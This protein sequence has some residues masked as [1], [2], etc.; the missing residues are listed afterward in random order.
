MWVE[1]QEKWNSGC[2]KHCPKGG[3]AEVSA[4][5]PLP[6]PGGFKWARETR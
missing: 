2:A 6:N 5:P 1:R 4:Q 3:K